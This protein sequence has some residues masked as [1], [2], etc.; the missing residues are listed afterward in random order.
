MWVEIVDVPVI[1]PARVRR[2]NYEAYTNLL[3]TSSLPLIAFAALV[4]QERV[5]FYARLCT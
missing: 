5:N 1:G 4:P 3:K 2:R